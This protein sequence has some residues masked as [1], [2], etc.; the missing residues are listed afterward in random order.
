MGLP[1]LNRNYMFFQCRPVS[2]SNTEI[3]MP[4]EIQRN[5]HSIFIWADEDKSPL[6]NEDGLTTECNYF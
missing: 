2:Y 6:K 4:W 5:Y 1:L 3:S